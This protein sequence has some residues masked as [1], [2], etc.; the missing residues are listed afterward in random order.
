M[1]RQEQYR[2]C[3]PAQSGAEYFNPEKRPSHPAATVTRKPPL[4]PAQVNG[5]A[6]NEGAGCAEGIDER[7]DFA[8]ETRLGGRPWP[9]CSSRR[10]RQDWRACLFV[11][12]TT[13]IAHRSRAAPCGERRPRYS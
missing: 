2:W 6:W 4:D 12:L 3:G 13:S 10:P 7:A 5:A 9:R 8:L 11:G 1:A